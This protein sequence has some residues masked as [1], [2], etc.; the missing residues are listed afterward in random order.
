MHDSVAT[1]YGAED[2]GEVRRLPW[3]R[4]WRTLLFLGL[5]VVLLVALVAV[6][7]AG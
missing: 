5:A 1:F 4:S 6:V 7:V 3:M 2:R